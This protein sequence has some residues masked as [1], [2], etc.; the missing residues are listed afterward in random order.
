[1][2][3]RRR[4]LPRT[5]L[6]TE[7]ANTLRKDMTIGEAM[8]WRSLSRRTMR[9][10]DFHRQTPIGNYIVDFYC[11]RLMLAIEVDGE[12]HRDKAAYD[13]QRQACIEGLGITVLRFDDALLRSRVQDVLR[14]IEAWIIAEEER[15]AK[16]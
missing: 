4:K 11:P 13:A 10:Y 15:E 9:G 6:S 2:L 16:G 5:Q 14:A 12:S 3:N 1:M 8:L 7:R